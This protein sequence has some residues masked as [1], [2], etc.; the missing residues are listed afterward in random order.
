MLPQR[1]ACPPFGGLHPVDSALHARQKLLHA[2]SVG[3]EPVPAVGAADRAVPCVHI[4]AGG[5]DASSGDAHLDAW[6]QALRYEGAVLPVQAAVAAA[7]AVDPRLALC[8]GAAAGGGKAHLITKR[9]ARQLAARIDPIAAT[10]PAA[11]AAEA[12][13][14]PRLRGAGAA[15]A[16]EAAR[17]S[18]AFL[19]A[20]AAAGPAAALCLAPCSDGGAPPCCDGGARGGPGASS[21][22]AFQGGGAACRLGLLPDLE[23][24]LLM[25]PLLPATEVRMTKAPHPWHAPRGR[26]QSMSALAWCRGLLANMHNLATFHAHGR[27]NPSV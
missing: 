1:F 22:A 26:G 6:S 12:A 11:A 24:P 20:A 10:A 27:E 7:A 5:S 16:R 18:R 2:C 21:D 14:R 17:Q 4:D 19:A 13:L 3:V 8:A 23:A 25:A 15:L 9:A